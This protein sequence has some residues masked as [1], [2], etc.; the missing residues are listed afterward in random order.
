MTLII[1]P[2]AAEELA[3]AA[4]WYEECRAGLGIEFLG[5]I[6]DALTRITANPMQCAV[7]ADEE[8]YRRLVVSRFPYLI[9]FEVR[10]HDLEVVAFAHASR[11]P[12]YWR[13]RGE[14]GSR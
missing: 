6:E 5:S 4:R 3:E 13:R 10:A 2:E 8:R 11:D 9:F 12:G 1:L 7:W 14:G